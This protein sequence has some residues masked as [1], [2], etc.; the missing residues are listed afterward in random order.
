MSTCVY[1]LRLAPSRQTLIN[2]IGRG[3]QSGRSGEFAP[4]TMACSEVIFL[5]LYDR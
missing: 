4:A 3:G 5:H 1:P 2:P